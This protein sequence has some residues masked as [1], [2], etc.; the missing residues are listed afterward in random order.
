V[1]AP[2]ASNTAAVVVKLVGGRERVDLGQFP[3]L[4]TGDSTATLL[5]NA[6]RY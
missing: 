6:L 3:D 4:Q 5:V 2:H 1:I